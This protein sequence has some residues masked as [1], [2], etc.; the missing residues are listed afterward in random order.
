M[1]KL[2]VFS[3]KS[4]N[5]SLAPWELVPE[6]SRTPKKKKG[7]KKER[8]LFKPHE[9]HE[10]I[11]SLVDGERA[12]RRRDFGDQA[13]PNLGLVG[14]AVTP[15]E[16]DY[17]ALGLCVDKDIYWDLLAFF[18][19]EKIVLSDR[20][21]IDKSEIYFDEKSVGNIVG[22]KGA[23]SNYGRKILFN[24][25]GEFFRNRDDQ[26]E[27]RTGEKLAF[28]LCRSVEAYIMN[29][30]VQPKE[31]RDRS[32]YEVWLQQQI[33]AGKQ[34]P[35]DEREREHEILRDQ[36][37]VK[38]AVLWD[39][40]DKMWADSSDVDDVLYCKGCIKDVENSVEDITQRLQFFDLEKLDLS[41]R[42]MKYR[43]DELIADFEK[44]FGRKPEFDPG[45]R[46]GVDKRLAVASEAH[47]LG[48]LAEATRLRHVAHTELL[49]LVQVQLSRAGYQPPPGEEVTDARLEQVKRHRRAIEAMSK[50][51]GKLF[52]NFTSIDRVDYAVNCKMGTAKNPL[53]VASNAVL[54]HGWTFGNTQISLEGISCYAA[55]CDNPLAKRGTHPHLCVYMDKELRDK[56]LIR[57]EFRI[58]AVRSPSGNAGVMAAA[59]LAREHLQTILAREVVLD[60]DPMSPAKQYDP[61][62]GYVDSQPHNKLVV[63]PLDPGPY[64]LPEHAFGGAYRGHAPETARRIGRGAV[65]SFERVV[66]AAI[67]AADFAVVSPADIEGEASDRVQLGAGL[68]A[69]DVE[70]V[71]RACLAW[72]RAFTP[73]VAPL[74][75]RVRT[76][77]IGTYPVQLAAPVPRQPLTAHATGWDGGC[78]TSPRPLV[79]TDELR[80]VELPARAPAALGATTVYQPISPPRKN[81]VDSYLL[82]Y[83]RTQEIAAKAWVGRY[84]RPLPVALNTS[85][86]HELAAASLTIKPY[87]GSRPPA[88]LAVVSLREWL[89]CCGFLVDWSTPVQPIRDYAR[90]LLLRFPS[91]YSRDLYAEEWARWE[92]GERSRPPR[93][94]VRA[95][96]AGAETDQD[97]LSRGRAVRSRLDRV[98]RYAAN[99]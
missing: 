94:A 16:L 61:A 56:G 43:V 63:Y 11:S 12:P 50:L 15:I 64:W 19:M 75:L 28:W 34:S 73:D 32:H 4:G 55:T 47:D 78:G 62:V 6:E 8:P 52:V 87:R 25:K 71:E 80:V 66:T 45:W 82:D 27:D 20:L 46:R 77:H 91:H 58:P 54:L 93:W 24:F 26:A 53:E 99:R 1:S 59:Q 42:F 48:A 39:L 7:Q 35:L 41:T 89:W 5:P 92:R 30:P 51:R 90:K 23:S 33:A 96:V 79:V 17:L 95:T 10:W 65:T 18:E 38:Q 40:R 21:Y 81:S 72:R 37:R 97:P 22:S 74:A 60:N 9:L 83:E 44:T 68:L 31:E 2:S 36:L 14:E 49:Q 86:P 85:S 57:F 98:A 88:P 67:V 29:L 13:N 76:S 3:D 84:K 69:E 70:R